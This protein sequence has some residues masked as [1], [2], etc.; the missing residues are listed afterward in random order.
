MAN[1]DDNE[2]RLWSTAELETSKELILNFLENYEK[3]SNW[4]IELKEL[5]YDVHIDNSIFELCTQSREINNIKRSIKEIDFVIEKHKEDSKA[6]QKLLESL[7]SIILSKQRN[8]ELDNDSWQLIQSLY[9]EKI[10]VKIL[11]HINSKAQSKTLK[12]NASKWRYKKFKNALLEIRKVVNQIEINVVSRDQFLID[13]T[14]NEQIQHLF[15]KIFTM[16]DRLISSSSNEQSTNKTNSDWETKSVSWDK[17]IFEI[18]SKI[19]IQPNYIKNKKI[20]LD[21]VENLE[22]SNSAS[23]RRS[24]SAEDISKILNPNSLARVTQPWTFRDNTK[25]SPFKLESKPKSK[26]K[27]ELMIN[28]DFLNIMH[29]QASHLENLILY[30]EDMNVE[31]DKLKTHN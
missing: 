15:S 14:E 26:P 9:G 8:I 31:F 25:V 19:I 2:P 22:L 20:D 18:D 6:I 21:K 17:S 24:I 23:K 12:R 7:S 1:L 29:M 4:I 27:S 16:I 28:S 5:Q 3:L 13:E 10:L 11:K 30:I